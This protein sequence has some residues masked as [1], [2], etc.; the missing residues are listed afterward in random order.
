MK[1][2]Q[3]NPKQPMDNEAIKKGIFKFLETNDKI[4]HT[5]TSGTQQKQY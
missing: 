2:K 5:K 4:Y 3:H 1:I